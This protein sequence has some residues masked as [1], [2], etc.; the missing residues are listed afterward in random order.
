[1][2]PGADRCAHVRTPTAAKQ[3]A[4]LNADEDRRARGGAVSAPK[5]HQSR[6]LFFQTQPDIQRISGA[7]DQ[8]RLR[9]KFQT[10]RIGVFHLLEVSQIQQIAFAPANPAPIQ[11]IAPLQIELPQNH[12]ILCLQRNTLDR[13]ILQLDHAFRVDFSQSKSGTLGNIPSDVDLKVFVP[14]FQS[15][16]NN[17]IDIPLGAIQVSNFKGV[18][19]QFGAIKKNARGRVARL[20]NFRRRENPVAR[21]GHLPKIV[22]LPLLD[23]K[24][25]FDTPVLPNHLRLF[26]FH[27]H[28][29]MPGILI[30]PGKPLHI[31]VQIFLLDL[32]GKNM[33]PRLFRANTGPFKD[34]LG[35]K[36]LIAFEFGFYQNK[37][38]PLP[39]V[40]PQRHGILGQVL[41]FRGHFSSR[42]SLFLVDLGQLIDIPLLLKRTVE[43]LSLLI[44]EN[45]RFFYKSQ[46]AA[47]SLIV[48]LLV[49]R[50]SQLAQQG[51]F[52]DLE[53]QP[54]AF[55][56][57][58]S[59]H[60]DVPHSRHFGRPLHVFPNG[61]LY[62]PLGKVLSGL[63]LKRL[64]NAFR[65]DIL[66]PFDP[67]LLDPI[68][69]C[70]GRRIPPAHDKNDQST[71]G[72]TMRF[73][74]RGHASPSFPG[75]TVK[76]SGQP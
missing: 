40:E 6:R 2:P 1:M 25:H 69:G 71:H 39:N 74:Q 54:N 65:I 37:F 14:G 52:R 11:N 16:L 73:S 18:L 30:E 13:L 22:S 10:R 15:R 72:K 59:S 42:K 27:L 32:L 4:L 8:F 17:R 21:R 19:F 58:F 60:Q 3:V 53:D 36:I 5:S 33:P 62:L 63:N 48:I 68:G 7:L 64:T 44:P 49:A 51:V 26:L 75:S 31:G 61:Q 56:E 47:Q 24:D 70:Q 55:G 12:E 43:N 41:G 57:R 67:N 28:P 34:F 66:S 38:L 76:D 35:G 23:S 50:K 20:G 9:A 46:F 29:I 45:A